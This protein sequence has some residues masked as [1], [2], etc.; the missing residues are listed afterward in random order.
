M[1]VFEKRYCTYQCSIPR[2]STNSHTSS[3]Y[4][5]RYRLSITTNE[6]INLQSI[7]PGTVKIDCSGA[8]IANDD[9]LRDTAPDITDEINNSS[10]STSGHL[11]CRNTSSDLEDDTEE[12]EFDTE[13]NGGGLSD[14]SSTTVE[15][16]EN[17]LQQ[18]QQQPLYGG[19]ITKTILPYHNTTMKSYI[20]RWI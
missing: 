14:S 4:I 1:P 20:Y 7:D 3:T 10:S 2:P 19:V 8:F 5:P 11:L 17:Q 18:L 13:E 15:D 12:S 6:D 9:L 16:D